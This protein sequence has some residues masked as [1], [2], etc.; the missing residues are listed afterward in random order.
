M[1]GCEAGGRRAGGGRAVGEGGWELSDSLDTSIGAG[2]DGAGAGGAGRVD[3]GMRDAAVVGFFMSREGAAAASAAVERLLMS[4]S[5]VRE[6]EALRVG[7]EEEGSGL[8]ECGL[9]WSTPAAFSSV[10]KD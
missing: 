1:K 3:R 10:Y 9:V 6:E 2:S 8:T 7:R 5:A 4:P